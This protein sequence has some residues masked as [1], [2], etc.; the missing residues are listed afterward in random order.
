MS[1]PYTLPWHLTGFTDCLLS[2]KAPKGRSLGLAK[3]LASDASPLSR[4]LGLNGSAPHLIE[5]VRLVSDASPFRDVFPWSPTDFGHLDVRLAKM[6]EPFDREFILTPDAFYIPWNLFWN[7]D[8]EEHKSIHEIIK[9][10]IPNVPNLPDSVLEN[11][12]LK[13]SA[14]MDAADWI[15]ECR[16]TPTLEN[17]TAGNTSIRDAVIARA[18]RSYPLGK[19]YDIVVLPNLWIGRSHITFDGQAFRVYMGLDLEWPDSER[20]KDPEGFIDFDS[21]TPHDPCGGFT[22][23]PRED[24]N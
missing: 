5:A 7:L 23:K 2:G 20:R 14:T 3:F 12:H 4:P 15:A 18:G 22:G 8:T 11:P 21:M 13:R 16:N 6:K 10:K 1:R 9:D 17:A 24:C 19:D